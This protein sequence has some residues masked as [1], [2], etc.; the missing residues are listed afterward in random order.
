MKKITII[1]I[2]F[3][4][5]MLIGC[6]RYD[7]VFSVG[8]YQSLET[9]VALKEIKYEYFPKGKLEITMSNRKE[10]VKDDKNILVSNNKYYSF[11]LQL[12]FLENSEWIKITLYNF[13]KNYLEVTFDF[14]YEIDGE[15]IVSWGSVDVWNQKFVNFSMLFSNDNQNYYNE[16]MFILEGSVF[17]FLECQFNKNYTND[18]SKFENIILKYKL[19]D[20][21]NDL[22]LLP[23]QCTNIYNDLVYEYEIFVQ[24]ENEEELIKAEILSI[25][26][27][28]DFG[29]N[30]EISLEFEVDIY[31][32][33][34]MLRLF[35]VDTFLI[36]VLSCEREFKG[37]KNQI[38]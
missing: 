23:N 11:D 27:I 8:K 37:I 21:K 19:I 38:N 12:F 31:R 24:F 20:D 36:N 29:L 32:Y 5:L 17:D 1:I 35:E 10:Y 13:H 22:D 2:L 14:T 33:N 9:N 26:N 6:V 7:Y 3:I 4:T 18:D 25:E 15:K 28:F 34:V 16:Y 30:Q